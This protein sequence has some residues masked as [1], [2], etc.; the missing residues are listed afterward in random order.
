[1]AENAAL[2]QQGRLIAALRQTLGLGDSEV[3][4]THISWVLLSGNYAYKLKKAV[5][6]GFLDYSTLERRHRFCLDELSLNRRYAPDLYIDV[7]PVTETH[8]HVQ[9]GGTGQALEWAV[10]MHRFPAGNLLSQMLTAGEISDTLLAE[11]G[12]TIA[13]FHNAL[14]ASS[15]ARDQS[16]A[17]G[18]ATRANFAVLRD[19]CREAFIKR[20]VEKVA[21][22]SEE[23]HQRIG[24]LLVQRQQDGHVRECHGDLH[25]NN[26]VLYE[27]RLLPFD[28]IEFNPELRHIDTM[29]EVAFLTMDLRAAGHSELA[30][31]F[32]DAYL[33]WSGDYGGVRLLPFFECYRAMVRAKVAALGGGC[34]PVPDSAPGRLQLLKYLAAAQPAYRPAP[35]LVITHGLS[36]S[37]K[38]FCAR[39]LTKH[40]PYIR[41]RSDVERKRLFGLAPDADSKAA[42]IDIYTHEATKRTYHHLLDLARN[43]LRDGIPVVVDAAFLKYA[44]RRQF[45]Q[46]ADE[47]GVAFTILSARAS[48][49]TLKARMAQRG[50]L[51]GE[52]SEADWKIVEQQLKW[53]EPVRADESVVTE[54]VDT[55]GDR[56]L[57]AWVARFIAKNAGQGS[58]AGH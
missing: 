32:L 34:E 50:S 19:Y 36:A 18:E 13:L 33:A 26:V 7:V 55:D 56:P 53:Q 17:L 4:E 1:M 6:F 2:S 3:L 39:L 10:R 24:A 57:E 40:G 8:G 46:L 29:S 52:P 51:N 9:L 43:L 30:A 16:A 49:P 38:S 47:C 54:T 37:G 48:Q 12:K 45:R 42:G 22:W 41:I 14:P 21:S 31:T 11:L 25:C 44:E 27:G 23:E 5:D 58:V 35:H 15:T 20:S 28:G